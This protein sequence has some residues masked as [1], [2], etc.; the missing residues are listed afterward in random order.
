MPV[1]SALTSRST[2]SSQ[3]LKNWRWNYAKKVLG[4][5]PATS[6]CLIA[7]GDRKALYLHKIYLLLARR[8]LELY[9]P[10]GCNNFHSIKVRTKHS[11]RKIVAIGGVDGTCKVFELMTSLCRLATAP[12]LVTQIF[13]DLLLIP[14]CDCL[15]YPQDF[16]QWNW[17]HYAIKPALLCWLSQFFV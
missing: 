16:Q 8:V 2:I 15:S 10:R 4:H 3:K 1:Y 13:D 9:S 6:K 5:G 7:H 14:L 11:F 17:C 12:L